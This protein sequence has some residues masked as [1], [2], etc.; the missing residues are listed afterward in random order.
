[1]EIN[2]ISV[3]QSLYLLAAVITIVSAMLTLVVYSLRRSKDPFLQFYVVVIFAVGVT[4]W[5]VLKWNSGSNQI[6]AVLIL[7]GLFLA[8]SILTITW[9]YIA[10]SFYVRNVKAIK[11]PYGLDHGH[12]NFWPYFLLVIAWV[13]MTVWL[14][15]YYTFD[16]TSIQNRPVLFCY[17]GLFIILNGFCR[18]IWHIIDTYAISR[19]SAGDLNSIKKHIYGILRAIDLDHELIIID[20]GD[21]R[22]IHITDVP[23]KS[24][25]VLNTLLNHRVRA[26]LTLYEGGSYEFRD[27]GPAP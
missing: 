21:N 23:E 1:M 15:L 8:V 24:H 26:E 17:F 5:L 9:R 3:E 7:Y 14:T 2:I 20:V 18:I 27:I 19:L 11:R 12:T 4:Y 25:E 13:L 22:R 16:E 10:L 6:K